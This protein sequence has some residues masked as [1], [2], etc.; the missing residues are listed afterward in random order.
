MK[1]P[2]I[3]PAQGRIVAGG[4]ATPCGESELPPVHLRPATRFMESF[5]RTLL[6]EPRCFR[7]RD[8]QPWRH[9]HR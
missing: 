3:S 7:F 1:V 5:I 4:V 6:P 2:L 8:L 9:A